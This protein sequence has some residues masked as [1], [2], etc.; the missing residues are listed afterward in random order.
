MQIRPHST[1]AFTLVEVALAAAVVGAVIIPLIGLMAVGLNTYKS[2]NSDMRSAL[3]AQKLIAANQMIPYGQLAGK[4]YLLDFD[5][6]EVPE[7]DAVFRARMLVEKNPSGG[8][9]Q[10]ANAARVSILLSGPALQNQTNTFS[11]LVVNR[12]Y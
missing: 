3:I 10:S 5:G 9:V 7:R 6:N 8:V 11:S 4:T 12:G 2:S 1:G